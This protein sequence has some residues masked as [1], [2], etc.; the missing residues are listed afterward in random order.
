MAVVVMFKSI[1]FQL[2]ALLDLKPNLCPTVTP[3][4]VCVSKPLQVN[5]V[6][7]AVVDSLVQIPPLMV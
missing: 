3:L 2:L 1:N 5:V 7:E 4:T 6:L